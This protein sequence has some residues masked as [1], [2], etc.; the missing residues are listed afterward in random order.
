MVKTTN[1]LFDIS[2]DTCVCNNCKMNETKGI[3]DGCL[4]CEDCENGDMH[5]E[6][7]SMFE[8]EN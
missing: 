1:G 5:C 6:N 2:C 4:D 7:C 3:Y 8:Q